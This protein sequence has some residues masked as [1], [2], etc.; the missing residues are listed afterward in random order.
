MTEDANQPTGDLRVDI[1]AFPEDR[2][3]M[4]RVFLTIGSLWILALALGVI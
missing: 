4:A 3:E 1:Y 2:L